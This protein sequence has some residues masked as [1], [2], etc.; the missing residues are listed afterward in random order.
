[1]AW[2]EARV[3]SWGQRIHTILWFANMFLVLHR[4][5]VVRFEP[6]WKE[7][8]MGQVGTEI[9]VLLR[10]DEDVHSRHY[11]I[12]LAKEY[13]RP[14]HRPS[15]TVSNLFVVVNLSSSDQTI[16]PLMNAVLHSRPSY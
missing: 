9:S 4:E 10:R 3:S 6:F 7:D 15:E 2:D 11:Y 13:I 14:Q 16:T 1:M 5:D 12:G 8:R